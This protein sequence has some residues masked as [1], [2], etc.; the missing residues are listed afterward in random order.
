MFSE[1]APPIT[2]SSYV[3]FSCHYRQRHFTNTESGGDPEPGMFK[4]G[5]TGPTGIRPYDRAVGFD[6]KPSVGCPMN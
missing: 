3:N 6:W 4:K 1:T 5:W 2:K